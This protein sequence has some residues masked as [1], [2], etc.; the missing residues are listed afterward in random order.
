[1]YT[2]VNLEKILKS[3][4]EFLLQDGDITQ[5]FSI[6]DLRQNVVDLR[7]AVTRPGS[8]DIG[9]S[10]KLSE[11]INKADGLLGDAFLGRVD[12]V[13]IKPDF[14]E[15]LIKLDLDQAMDGSLDNDIS[16]QGLDRVQVYGTTGLVPRTYVS[17]SGH[18]KRPGKF[19]LQDNMTLYDLIFKSGGF[20][21]EEY[22]K[23]TYLNRA[24]LVRFK[25]GS[26]QKEIIIN[27]GQVLNKEGIANTILRV[28]DAVQCIALPKL[29][30]R[31]VMSLLVAILKR[32]R[33]ELFEEEYA[34]LTSF[35]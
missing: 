7:G 31:S 25:K 32:G 5:I 8:Y 2:D 1:M 34:Y 28:D 29:K 4:D 10:L 22:K 26:D 30:G 21:D 12:I 16:L 18:V 9:D 13:R 6:L 24:E 19:L 14:T 35:I 27:L 3:K 33:Y 20:V 15:E 17:I 23:L 11:L